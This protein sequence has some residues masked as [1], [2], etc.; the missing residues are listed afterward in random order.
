MIRKKFARD[1]LWHEGCIESI[2]KKTKWYHEKYNNGD[3]EDMTIAEIRK[4]QVEIEPEDKNNCSKK[5]QQTKESFSI[6]EKI[7]VNF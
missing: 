2:I 1:G 5:K 7:K 6:S 3:A 4:H